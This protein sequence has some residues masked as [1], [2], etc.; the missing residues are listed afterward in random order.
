MSCCEEDNITWADKL[1]KLDRQGENLLEKY[2]LSTY[3]VQLLG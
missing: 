2:L 1:G 3:D